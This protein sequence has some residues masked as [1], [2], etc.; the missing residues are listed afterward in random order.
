M[1]GSALYA[2]Y[3]PTLHRHL[4][5]HSEQTQPQPQFFNPHPNPK[6]PAPVF[7]FVILSP[8]LRLFFSYDFPH[9]WRNIHGELIDNIY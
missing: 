1:I 3:I 6:I 9:G 4:Y 2:T 5:K 8:F 7:L